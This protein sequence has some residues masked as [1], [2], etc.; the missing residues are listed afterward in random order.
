MQFALTQA[1]IILALINQRRLKNSIPSEGRL[2]RPSKGILQIFCLNQTRVQQVVQ[3]F[4]S[5][6][7][8]AVFLF[9]QAITKEFALNVAKESNEAG[10]KY[11]GNEGANLY[12]CCEELWGQYQEV[13]GQQDDAE[14]AGSVLLYCEKWFNRGKEFASIIEVL[15]IIDREQ[16]DNITTN[17]A[18][19][20]KVYY[21]KTISLFPFLPVK[22]TV[23]FVKMKQL[24]IPKLGLAKWNNK[25]YFVMGCLRYYLG[26][27]F[28]FI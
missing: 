26:I 28:S 14:V 17:V 21:L 2:W 23:S 5:S 8:I 3:N 13:L 1:V 4:Y 16:A 10:E 24:Y 15:A 7:R 11:A 19:G 6:A 22:A 25:T 12:C 27:K 18:E 20:M 9:L